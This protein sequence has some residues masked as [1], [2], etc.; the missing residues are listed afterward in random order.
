MNR[1][2]GDPAPSSLA[3]L[4]QAIRTV[5]LIGDAHAAAGD[6]QR[7]QNL[8]QISRERLQAVHARYAACRPR[9]AR[10]GAGG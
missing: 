3:L 5:A 7:A 8:A 6:L 1:R 4:G 2:A 9:R 10:A